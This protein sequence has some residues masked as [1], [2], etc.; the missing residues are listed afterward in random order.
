MGGLE[1]FCSNMKEPKGNLD[2]LIASMNAMN[3]EPDP[4]EE[5]MKGGSGHVGKMI[6]SSSDEGDDAQCAAVG[7]VP[8]DK[9]GKINA[10]EWMEEVMKSFQPTGVIVGEANAGW[11]CAIVKHSPS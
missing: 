3:K 1:F 5:E 4:E 6:F 7:Y 10:K 11:A 2:L 8:A 9:Q